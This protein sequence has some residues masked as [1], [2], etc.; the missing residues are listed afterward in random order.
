MTYSHIRLKGQT[1][2]FFLNDDRLDEVD[3]DSLVHL[4]GPFTLE[5]VQN[6]IKEYRAAVAGGSNYNPKIIG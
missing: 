5:Q 6:H 1:N 2:A 4:T 3:N